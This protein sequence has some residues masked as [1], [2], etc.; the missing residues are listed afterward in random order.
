MRLTPPAARTAAAC[1][2]LAGCGAGA[3]PPPPEVAGVRGEAIDL[4]APELIAT[5]S[6]GVGEAFELGFTTTNIGDVNNDGYDD[7][8]VS[9]V[10]NYDAVAPDNFGRVEVY[11]GDPA[12]YTPGAW[13]WEQF[14]PN[15]TDELGWS[16]GRSGDVDGDGID[17]FFI[18][19]P[20]SNSDQGQL[21]LFRGAETSMSGVPWWTG[22]GGI[23]GERYGEAVAGIGDVNGDLRGDFVVGRPGKNGGEGGVDLYFGAAGGPAWI[24]ELN[25]ELSDHALGA[26][27]AFLGDVD[28]DGNVEVLAGSPQASSS[29]GRADVL[30]V[31]TLGPSLVIEQTILGGTD[32]L[33]QAVAGPGDVTGDGWPDAL[34]GAPGAAGGG[35]VEVYAGSTSGGD[36]LVHWVTIPGATAEGETEVGFR[37]GALG[38]VNGDGRPDFGYSRAG[39]GVYENYFTV[40]YAAE[41]EGTPQVGGDECFGES[42]FAGVDDDGDGF[43]AVFVG[44]P[45]H[46]GTGCPAGDAPGRLQR[47][48]SGPEGLVVGG[49]GSPTA[50]WGPLANFAPDQ[51]L[52]W[53]MATVDFNND[54]Y[55]DLVV[56]DDQSSA[57]GFESGAARI[58]LGA[59][60]AGFDTQSDI[61]LEPPLLVGDGD[62]FG[63]AVAGVGDVN[64]D[65]FEDVAV[66]APRADAGAGADV[67]AGLVALYLGSGAPASVESAATYVEGLSGGDGNLQLPPDS[68]DPGGHLGATLAG[69]DLDG[70]GLSEIAAGA[71]YAGGICE[72]RVRVF[73]WDSAGDLVEEWQHNGVTQRF[74]TGTSVAVTDMSGDGLPDL[75]IGSPGALGG[76]LSF[77]TFN[78]RVELFLGQTEFGTS[79]TSADEIIDY[80]T[81]ESDFGWQIA[82]AG[83]VN[84]DGHGDAI[85]SAP[86]WNCYTGKVHLLLGGTSPPMTLSP[87]FEEVGASGGADNALH[88]AAGDFNG[89][90]FSDVAWGN[91]SFGGTIPSCVFPGPYDPPVGGEGEIKVAYGAANVAA[92]AAEFAVIGAADGNEYGAALAAGDVDADGFADLFVAAPVAGPGEITGFPGNRGEHSSVAVG[93]PSIRATAAGD[94]TV[95]LAPG[96][97]VGDV[98]FDLL[99]NPRVLRGTGGVLLQ[100]EVVPVGS[101]FT[102]VPTHAQ[103]NFTEVN[104]L[105]LGEL[106]LTVDNLVDGQWIKVRGRLAYDPLELPFTRFGPWVELA[107]PGFGTL[108]VLRAGDVPAGDD[109]D[110]VGP[111]DD[112]TLPDDDDD[113][114]PDDDDTGPECGPD[115]DGDGVPPCGPDGVPGT[116]DDDCDDGDPTSYGGA[117]ELCDGVDNDCDA[118]TTAEGGEFDLDGDGFRVCDD[119]ADGD[120]DTFP[121]ADELCD[122]L[123]ND[124]DGAPDHDPLGEIDGDGDGHLSCVDC[125]DDDAAIHPGAVEVCN[126]RD[127][128]CDFSIDEDADA[129][130]DGDGAGGCDDPP[131]CAPFDPLVYPGAPEA[132]DGIDS[133]CGGEEEPD[134][135]GDGAFACGDEGDCDDADPTVFPGAEEDCGNG[136]DENCDGVDSDTDADGDGYTACA[137]GDCDDGDPAVHPAATEACDGVDTNC[138]GVLGPAE[139]DADNDGFPACGDCNDSDPEVHPGAEERCNGLDDDCDGFSLGG[140]ELDFDNDGWR[141]CEGDCDDGEPTTHL[142]ALEDCADGVDNN[143]NGVVDEAVDN[144]GD[145]FTPC[146]GTVDGGDCRDDQ[147][148]VG[149]HAE[150]L[151]DGFDNDCDGAIDE[152]PDGTDSDGDGAGACDCDDLDPDVYV[153][154]PHLCDGKDNDCD[155]ITE[156]DDDVDR[157]GDGHRVC[158]PEEGALGDCRDHNALIHPDAREV[159]D[160]VDNNCDG[161]IDE[162]WDADA[163][164][165]KLCGFDCD[166]GSDTVNPPSPEICFNGIDE[167]CDSAADEGCPERTRLSVPPGH[168]CQCDS[169]VAGGR[170]SASVAV[171]LLLLPL[172]RRRRRT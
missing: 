6:L 62:R 125:D 64:G 132:C 151:C 109:D 130:Y 68:W 43:P 147:A 96:S 15:P 63:F 72:G 105:S 157:D 17:D 61:G 11:Y 8:A 149:P 140:A 98:E 155:F 74:F 143:C 156:E 153:G 25:G 89:D 82:A 23:A 45:Y 2:L 55:D 47:Y 30:E 44:S 117:P 129:D 94:P 97:T 121:G 77:W 123:D 48:G 119:C 58:Y 107:D 52:G 38:D 148:T 100:A 73:G 92:M 10:K 40:A 88:L 16:V 86:T 1:F 22:F 81:P 24:D 50:E 69:G 136:I 65:G 160:N 104:P 122:G 135:D 134:A 57:W 19:V 36:P 170:G 106:T 146:V 127:D 102:G 39:T 101:P 150:E 169:D 93:V 59:P 79:A 152:D 27:L 172:T 115:G 7:V 144:D 145:G 124:C 138:D 118:T 131:D 21:R 32:D 26:N 37:I 128:D 66:G 126:G 35:K 154:A 85:V 80:A 4:A 78:G 70:D 54:G 108:A 95:P 60:D 159:C 76:I 29:V 34:I 46:T 71:P 142:W 91:P 113:T 168:A 31:D 161:V 166:D 137:G 42:T 164:Q 18:R 41:T 162:T 139:Q 171:L 90:G 9:S 120:P 28:D 103:T 158:P 51:N 165:W 167:D 141:P 112:D 99:M 14:S 67:W 87:D 20:G 83:D 111:D 133:D 5:G 53:A 33:G 163:D 56:G 49:S 114:G 110:D 75:L 84:G 3:E 13:D 116:P 12:G